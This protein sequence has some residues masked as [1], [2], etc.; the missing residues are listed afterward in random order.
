MIIEISIRNFGSIREKQT[1]SFEATSSKELEEYYVIE[2]IKGVRLLKLLY[3]YGPN[4]SGK[5]T[6]LKALEFLRVLSTDPEDVKSSNLD[7]SP[8]LL[9]DHSRNE[10][11]KIELSFISEGIRYAYEVEFTRQYIVS[12][13]LSYFPKNRIAELYHRTTDSEALK[14]MVTFGSTVKIGS[15]DAL[16]LQGNTI[17]NN[18]VLGAL[19]KSNVD[20]EAL[21]PV[22][23]WFANY[24]LPTIEPSTDL[25]A[26][27]QDLIN[28][29]ELCFDSV[30]KL[31]SGADFLM[32]GISFTET[33][34]EVNDTLIER[35]KN[36]ADIDEEFLE[37]IKSQQK[38]R[39]K[40]I[41]FNH[42]V[43]IGDKN[44]IY[45]MS[46]G[47]QSNGTLRYYSLA[48]PI[49]RLIN[50]GGMVPIDEIETSLH[51]DLMKHLI[52]HFL[53]N[54]KDAQ[55]MLT[56][57][58]YFLLEEREILRNDAIYLV[59]KQDTGA[60]EIYSLVEFDSSILRK[61]SSLVNLYRSG[62]LGAKPNPVDVFSG[63]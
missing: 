49:T 21:N 19:Y 24:L 2:P 45:K 9:D 50:S 25:M 43:K 58:N 31:I 30:N 42:K 18:S 51:P 10:A 13:K 34:V 7:F 27:T 44:R 3:I 56:T 20:V 57:H 54:A 33:D 12:E 35:L 15:N 14:S 32:N 4:A 60:S 59:E 61:S 23:R 55:M 17:S 53:V 39:I 5:T 48:G 29:D 11:S 36:Q 62:R 1:I 22:N 26:W 8:F 6:V 47:R 37:N 46:R 28:N 38:L 63:K 41:R 16:I 40:N 52:M